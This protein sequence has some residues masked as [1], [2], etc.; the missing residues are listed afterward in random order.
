M[1]LVEFSLLLETL[2]FENRGVYPPV[3]LS[4]RD[5]GGNPR[6]PGPADDKDLEVEDGGTAAPGP[7]ASRLEPGSHTGRTHI[8]HQVSLLKHRKLY[9]IYIF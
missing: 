1:F 8:F 4:G 7:A 3:L 5:R 9:I 2:Q 6:A